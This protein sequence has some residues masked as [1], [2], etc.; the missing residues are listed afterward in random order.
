L[1]WKF[2][3]VCEIQREWRLEFA[4]Q[5]ATRLT[6]ARIRDKFEADDTAH[7]PK[8]RSFCVLF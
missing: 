7:V 2:E 5:P 4:A 6:V 3:N 8:Q 1:Y